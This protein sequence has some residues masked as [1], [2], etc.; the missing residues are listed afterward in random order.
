MPAKL[1]VLKDSLAI[2]FTNPVDP[3]AATNSDN[4]NMKV[5][6]HLNQRLQLSPM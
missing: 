5:E 1:H 2:T 6:L 4:Y 3:T